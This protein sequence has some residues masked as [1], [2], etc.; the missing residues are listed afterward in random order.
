LLLCALM[1]PTE[2]LEPKPPEFHHRSDVAKALGVTLPK[3]TYFFYALEGKRRYSTFE[4]HSK[5]GRS[6]V[7][8]API[9]PIKEIQ[10]KLLELLTP[11]YI[12]GL[13]STAMSVIEA[14]FRT[15]MFT[16]INAGFYM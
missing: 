3:L 7:I 6:R 9:P 1:P 10:Q 8:R 13:T 15:Q 2:K 5:S 14:R 11:A 4:I 12:R 16:S